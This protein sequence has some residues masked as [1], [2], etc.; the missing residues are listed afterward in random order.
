MFL[1]LLQALALICLHGK[2]KYLELTKAGNMDAEV[3]RLL[4]HISSAESLI[5]S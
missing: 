5:D 3:F 2:M 4:R 1:A